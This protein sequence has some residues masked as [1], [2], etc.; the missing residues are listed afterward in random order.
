VANFRRASF[1]PST[2]LKKGCLKTIHAG[3]PT[4]LVVV[5]AAAHAVL[6]QHAR[7][8]VQLIRVG[9]YHPGVAAG[10]QV[11]GGIKAES[12]GVA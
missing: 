10:A 12:R 2:D 4:H 11:L 6:A 7:P 1:Q 8:L 3:V 5:V 9:G